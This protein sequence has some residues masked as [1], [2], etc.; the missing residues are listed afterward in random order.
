[1]VGFTPREA[2]DPAPAVLPQLVGHIAHRDRLIDPQ[3]IS[4]EP[5]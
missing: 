2:A 1:L 3:P 5:T 4:D